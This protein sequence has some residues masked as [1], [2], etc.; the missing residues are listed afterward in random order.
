MQ[1]KDN[2]TPFIKAARGGHLSTVRLLHQFNKGYANPATVKLGIIVAEDNGHTE[3]I[4]YLKSL[5]M[6]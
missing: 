4:K 6:N 1:S 3:V 2:L 5:G